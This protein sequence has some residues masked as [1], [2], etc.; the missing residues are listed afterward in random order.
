M[1]RMEK[2]LHHTIAT[3]WAS[4]EHSYLMPAGSAWTKYR[5]NCQ[6]RVLLYA[7]ILRETA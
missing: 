4:F 1:N 6:P 5:V 2:A 3:L 7:C